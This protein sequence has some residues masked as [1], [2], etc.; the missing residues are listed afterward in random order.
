MKKII[1]LI[2][3]CAFHVFFLNAQVSGNTIQVKPKVTVDTIPPGNTIVLDQLVVSF[4][5][6]IIIQGHVALERKYNGNM[7]F[8]DLF[9]K[10]GTII[11]IDNIMVRQTNGS[12][13][14]RPP[15]KYVVR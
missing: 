13:V 11:I 12:F 3:S 7:L 1:L 4:T 8:G 9:M 5:A 14:K 2:L 15:K 6:C 10:P